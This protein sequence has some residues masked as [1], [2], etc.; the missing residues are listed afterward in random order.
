MMLI[1]GAEGFIA[2][3]FVASL[4]GDDTIMRFDAKRGDGGCW[5]PE[6][7]AWELVGRPHSISSVVHF[8]GITDTTCTDERALLEHNKIGR[9]HV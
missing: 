1:S 5:T 2:G 3:H 6:R 9:A 4:T 7:T 8:G